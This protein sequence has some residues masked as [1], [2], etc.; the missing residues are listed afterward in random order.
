MKEQLIPGFWEK[1]RATGVRY[2]RVRY[3]NFSSHHKYVGSSVAKSSE[4]V[5]SLSLFAQT[6]IIDAQDPQDIFF[7]CYCSQT[8]EILC[9]DS[10]IRKQIVQFC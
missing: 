8:P 7:K 2:S 6:S 5:F 1:R 9:E 4:P 3:F 10:R